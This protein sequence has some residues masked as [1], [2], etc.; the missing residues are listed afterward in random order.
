[1]PHIFSW[2]PSKSQKTRIFLAVLLLAGL[3][4][5][6]LFFTAPTPL[7]NSAP[8]ISTKETPED[9]F[10]KKFSEELN[11]DDD[12]DGLKNWEEAIYGTDPKNPD[13]DGDK[14]SDGNEIKANR[15]PLI[16]GP[17]DTVLPD[18]ENPATFVFDEKSLTDL[19][20]D[21]VAKNPEF[22]LMLQ[23]QGGTVSDETI[24][25]YLRELPISNIQDPAPP[26]ES[27]LRVSQDTSTPAVQAYFDNVTNIYVKHGGAFLH[28][29]D[30]E[31]LSKFYTT[32]DQGAF[33]QLIEM[34]NA[35][36]K[37]I[38]ETNKLSIPKNVVWFHQKEIVLL[39]KTK[40]ELSLM[41]HVEDDP[42]A[43]LLAAQTR[44]ETKDAITDL[45][46]N[47]L[48]NWLLENNIKLNP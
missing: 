38:D 12:N 21:K 23:N 13:T 25:K 29:S 41:I 11:K 35:F 32:G 5:L 4:F 10:R 47:Q 24:T 28:G 2:F 20:L 3:L 34:I 45:H 44:P 48:T 16:K 17:K 14:T 19:F 18:E 31:L 30:A 7:T 40:N 22:Q 46:G 33:K 27:S 43:A 6:I 9:I 26:K 1:M 37:I 39:Q 15:N 8:K 42:L 36:Q